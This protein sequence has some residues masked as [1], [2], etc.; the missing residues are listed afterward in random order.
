MIVALIVFSLCFSL[1]HWSRHKDK[2]ATCTCFDSQGLGH[3]TFEMIHQW[4]SSLQTRIVC[5]IMLPLSCLHKLISL[6]DTTTASA[7]SER[8]LFSSR[9][10]ES[11][12]FGLNKSNTF[13]FL[14]ARFI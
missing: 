13:P 12:L 9:P 6:I 4:I 1:T 11:G 7:R 2:I 3:K 10:E 14:T 5:M 8:L